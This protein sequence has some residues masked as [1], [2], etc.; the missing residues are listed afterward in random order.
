MISWFTQENK[1]T[2]VVLG[3]VPAPQFEIFWPFSQRHLNRMSRSK[4]SSFS[5]QYYDIFVEHE[6]RLMAG[7]LGIFDSS[8]I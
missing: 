3:V 8:S 6:F 5:T 2:F 7:I 1:V 4:H